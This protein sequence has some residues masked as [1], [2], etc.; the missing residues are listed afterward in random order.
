MAKVF[1][2]LYALEK[3]KNYIAPLI[4]KGSRLF[5]MYSKVKDMAKTFQDGLE[6]ILAQTRINC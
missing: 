1:H 5:F 6:F 4:H 3:E 2:V